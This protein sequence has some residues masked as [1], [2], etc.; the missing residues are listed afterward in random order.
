MKPAARVLLLVVFLG[1]SLVCFYN[2]FVFGSLSGAPGPSQ[3]EY[4]DVA[5]LYL[6]GGVSL[7]GIGI[8]LF[9]ILGRRKSQP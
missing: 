6:L 3:Q 7:I 5:N 9:V 2:V 8:G 1:S 4:K